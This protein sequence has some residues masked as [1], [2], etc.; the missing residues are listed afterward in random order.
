MEK[1][2]EKLLLGLSVST[3]LGVFGMTPI[4][5]GYRCKIMSN[6]VVWEN[7]EKAS[8]EYHMISYLIF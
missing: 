7:F 8:A 6:I 3:R 1:K 4:L 5:E 2:I